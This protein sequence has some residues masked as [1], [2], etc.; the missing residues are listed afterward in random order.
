MNLVK[1]SKLEINGGWHMHDFGMHMPS[2]SLSSINVPVHSL[3]LYGT[4][5][6][7]YT[8]AAVVKVA[9]HGIKGTYFPFPNAF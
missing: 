5:G 7:G 4:G 2:I 3:L 9:V 6:G 1:A 8:A